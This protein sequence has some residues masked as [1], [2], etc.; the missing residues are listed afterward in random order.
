M[1]EQGLPRD[2]R[3]ASLAKYLGARMHTEI[4]YRFLVDGASERIR[5]LCLVQP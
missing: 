3:N 5:M 1:S 4:M 2:L